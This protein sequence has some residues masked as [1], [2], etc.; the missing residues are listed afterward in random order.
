MDTAAMEAASDEPAANPEVPSAPREPLGVAIGAAIESGIMRSALAMFVAKTAPSLLSHGREHGAQAARDGNDRWR[1]LVASS[2]GE[3][4]AAEA[5]KE[6]GAILDAAFGPAEPEWP[7]IPD[8]FRR[9]F[10]GEDR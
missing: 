9:A 5:H 7:D 8:V 3:A 2:Q 10:E 1:K 4:F 6:M